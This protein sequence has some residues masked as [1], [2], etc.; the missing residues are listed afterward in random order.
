MA[1]TW[2]RGATAPADKYCRPKGCLAVLGV[3]KVNCDREIGPI[4]VNKGYLAGSQSTGCLSAHLA[5]QAYPCVLV[6]GQFP[7]AVP[8]EAQPIACSGW[9]TFLG[10][11]C[12]NWAR[13]SSDTLLLGLGYPARPATGGSELVPGVKALTDSNLDNDNPQ[14]AR[15]QSARAWNTRRPPATE[16]SDEKTNGV[17]DILS[18][19]SQRTRQTERAIR[20][21]KDTNGASGTDRPTGHRVRTAQDCQMS[22]ATQS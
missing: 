2:L 22:K 9:L 15:S 11:L 7:W 1:G 13:S 3:V 4:P 5:L 18:G 21:D 6:L 17:P 19:R 14:V 8:L 20:A 16:R 10:R 12:S